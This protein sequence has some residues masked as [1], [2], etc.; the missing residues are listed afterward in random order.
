MRQHA[1]VL[2][3]ALVRREVAAV[4]ERTLLVAERLE[5][6]LQVLLELLIELVRLDAERFLEGVV[7][8]ADDALAQREDELADAFLAPLRFHELEGGVAEVVG[9]ARIAEAAVVLE[10]GHLRHDVGHRDVAHAHQIERRPDAGHVVG[11]AFVDPQ[12]EAAADQRARDD[13]ELEHVGQFVRDQAIELIGRFVDRQH[14]ALALRLGERRHAFGHFHRRDVLLLELGV[15]LE[16]HERHLEAELVLQ[17]GADVLIGAL[18]VRRRP[19]EMLLELR[20]VVDL[21][22]I[23][24]VD[25]PPERVV[26]DAVLPEVRDEVGLGE[27]LASRQGQSQQE[28]IAAGSSLRARLVGARMTITSVFELDVARVGCGVAT[29]CLILCV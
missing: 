25:V 6:I 2:R 28:Q 23:G 19:F 13:V 17:L 3:A 21:E 8:A 11:H 1:A 27:S 29:C 18:R 24:G 7:A 26:V 4:V 15:R 14:H 9:D 20:V 12:R 10:L 22:V 5:A 16:Q